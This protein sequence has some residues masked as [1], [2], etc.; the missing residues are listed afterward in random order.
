M[1]DGSEVVYHAGFPNA[2]ETSEV[3]G[4]SLDTLIVQH[5]ASTYFWRLTDD[6]CKLLRVRSGTLAVVDRSLVPRHEDTVVIVVDESFYV[7]QFRQQASVAVLVSAKGDVEQFDGEVRIW[8]V[9]TYLVQP[10]RRQTI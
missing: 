1:Q 10:M 5:Q 2:A 4:L 6:A 3:M 7:R 9:V 8:G